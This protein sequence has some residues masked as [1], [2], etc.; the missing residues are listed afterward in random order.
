M[1][2]ANLPI[3]NSIYQKSCTEEINAMSNKHTMKRPVIEMQVHEVDGEAAIFVF[4]N[5]VKIA[6]RGHSDSPQVR[7]CGVYNFSLIADDDV[8][9]LARSQA[10]DLCIDNTVTLLI[11]LVVSM[12][13]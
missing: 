13:L 10:H 4:A 12:S 2:D 6:K 1:D 11:G 5:S 7:R 3:E 9:R 8:Y